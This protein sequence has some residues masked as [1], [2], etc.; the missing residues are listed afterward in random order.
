MESN[1]EEAVALPETLEKT[2]PEARLLASARN[3]VFLTRG[4]LLSKTDMDLRVFW[5]SGQM[6]GAV[7]DD[8]EFKFDKPI[9]VWVPSPSG[10]LAVL[11]AP[12]TKLWPRK[13][14]HLRITPDEI[15]NK[16]GVWFANQTEVGIPI[17]CE[18]FGLVPRTFTKKDCVSMLHVKGGQSNALQRMHQNF[19]AIAFNVLLNPNHLTEI[20]DEPKL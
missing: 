13:H 12:L 17:P 7:P 2:L 11:V 6:T 14:K 4:A 1:N 3:L 9:C 8:A 18:S 10:A 15:K 20:H 16:V 5:Y 19:A